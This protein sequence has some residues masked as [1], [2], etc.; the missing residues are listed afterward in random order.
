[1]P[2]RR[3]LSKASF[4]G[5]GMSTSVRRSRSRFWGA[6]GFSMANIHRRTEPSCSSSLDNDE[7]HDDE[8]MRWK[9]YG[10]RQRPANFILRR[11]LSEWYIATGTFMENFV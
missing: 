3:V 1:M 6:Q 7:E 5:G 10:G 8:G 9:S 4:L 2:R 11:W